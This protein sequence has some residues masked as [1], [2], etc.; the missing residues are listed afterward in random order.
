MSEIASTSEKTAK[1]ARDDANAVQ[2]VSG[3]SLGYEVETLRRRFIKRVVFFAVLLSFVL[4]ISYEF[5]FFLRSD[6]RW[7]FPKIP[8]G[9]PENVRSRIPIVGLVVVPVQLIA[10]YFSGMFRSIFVYFRIPELARVGVSMTIAFFALFVGIY[11]CQKSGFVVAKIHSSAIVCDYL[12]SLCAVVG[13]RV[14]ARMVWERKKTLGACP[15]E[16][17]RVAAIFGAGNAGSYLA[18]TLLARSVLGIKVAL[19]LD[20]DR[21]KEGMFCCGLP[22]YQVSDD[23]SVLRDSYH[24]TDLI[25]AVPNT[26]V[27]RIREVSEIARKAG[28]AVCRV[29]DVGDLLAGRA[30]ISDIHEIGVED[31]LE[32]NPVTLDRASIANMISGKCVM[33]TGAGGSIGSEICRQCAECGAARV[34]LVEQCEVLLYQIEQDLIRRGNGGVIVPLVADIL[35]R[36]RI[37]SIFEKY[38]PDIV[39]HAAAHKHVP[40]ME[41]QPGEAIKNNALGTAQV[42]ELSS[43]FG[44]EAFVCISTDKAINPTNAMGASKRL[45]EIILQA[46]ASRAGN[47]TRFMAVRFGNVLGSSGSVIPLF[48]RQIA[49][50]GPVTVTHRDIKRYFMTIPEAVGLVLQ[51]A[52]IGKSGNIYVL[53]MGEPIKIIDLANHMIRL[54]GLRPNI[55]IEI[56]I[57]GLRPGEKL[58]EEIKT[59]GEEFE[60]SGFPQIVRFVSTPMPFEKL[61]ELLAELREIAGKPSKNEIKQAIHR[62]VPEYQPYLS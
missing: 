51:T 47:R 35:D 37:V 31:L 30:S 43:K 46:N 28:L 44:V 14:A 55:D 60:P 29:P 8:E 12:L 7:I 33:I 40:M 56:K 4:Y 20:D 34:L 24:L 2:N 1:P 49:D 41:S 11:F 38:H 3:A 19:F 16:R 45:A 52:V 18:S 32:R 62:L 50:G 54:S 53:D 61:D 59:K 39:F 36:P 22:I 6:C 5:E 25:L 48:K 23:L 42:V 27:R 57:T 13:I 58:F 15:E 10:L 21:R 17:R 26:A 9:V